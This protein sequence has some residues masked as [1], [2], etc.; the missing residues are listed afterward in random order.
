MIDFNILYDLKCIHCNDK[1]EDFNYV[2]K[3][4]K[5]SQI[6]YLKNKDLNIFLKNYYGNY[7]D[8]ELY[9]NKDYV[10]LLCG[11][12]CNLTILRYCPKSVILGKKPQTYTYDLYI[13]SIYSS[14]S[15][16][17]DLHTN[18]LMTQY[19]EF[20]KENYKLLEI[21][22][23]LNNIKLFSKEFFVRKIRNEVILL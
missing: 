1:F 5:L 16:F 11:C 14:Y 8:K 10:I 20:D 3:D 9:G 2:V 13:K 17:Y 12:S 18:V 19:D 4:N 6:K 23:P 15:Q 21:N 22:I 7:I